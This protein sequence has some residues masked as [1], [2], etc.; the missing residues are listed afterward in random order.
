MT[1]SGKE[2]GSENVVQMYYTFLKIYM[3]KNDT[4]L[5]TIP[6]DLVSRAHVLSKKNYK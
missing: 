6:Y 3:G 1:F 2:S 5:W 4:N